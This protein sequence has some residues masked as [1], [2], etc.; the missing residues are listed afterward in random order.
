MKKLFVT[1]SWLDI[2]PKVYVSSVI[3]TIYIFEIITH[4]FYRFNS[5]AAFLNNLFDLRDESR[6]STCEI[7]Y[8][9]ERE[10]KH[11]L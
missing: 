5:I 2:D 6:N 11:F 8:R 4:F 3:T 10:T 7:S 9:L 1:E